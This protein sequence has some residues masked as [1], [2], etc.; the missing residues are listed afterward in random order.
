MFQYTACELFVLD[1]NVQNNEQDKERQNFIGISFETFV[2]HYINDVISPFKHILLLQ[3]YF[4]K[5]STYCFYIFHNTISQ[6]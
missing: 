2:Q 5:Y 3:E 4:F 6:S 1:Y